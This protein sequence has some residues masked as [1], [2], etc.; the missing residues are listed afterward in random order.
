MRFFKLI[1]FD[2]M[3][4]SVITPV[5]S[6]VFLSGGF[7]ERQ[8]GARP[9]PRSVKKIN[10]QAISTTFK[11]FYVQ[12]ALIESFARSANDASYR[13]AIIE[14]DVKESPLDIPE[15]PVP[16]EVSEFW[17]GRKHRRNGV[18]PGVNVFEDNVFKPRE[19]LD[20]LW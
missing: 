17:L 7:K 5:P 6:P 4:S 15:H 18:G 1:D 3:E 12:Q 13:L 19:G 14:P 16:D 8:Q 10:P 2:S 11:I 20:V 9:E